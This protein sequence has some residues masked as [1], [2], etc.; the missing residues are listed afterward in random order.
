[1]NRAR[2]TARAPNSNGQVRAPAN[3]GPPTRPPMAQRFINLEQIQRDLPAGTPV[4]LDQE[5]VALDIHWPADSNPADIHAQLFGPLTDAIIAKVHEVMVANMPGLPCSLPKVGRHHQYKH[6]NGNAVQE[7]SILIPK[8][9]RAWLASSPAV[10]RGH[11]RLGQIHLLPNS[12]PIT[13][14]VH[15]KNFHKVQPAIWEISGVPSTLSPLAIPSF[16]AHAYSSERAPRRMTEFQ[17]LKPTRMADTW[18][19]KMAPGS[20]NLPHQSRFSLGRPG[21]SSN[22]GMLVA[23]RL[24]AA[25]EEAPFLMPCKPPPRMELN[26]QR[27]LNRQR[28]PSQQPILPTQPIARLSGPE[29]T[30]SR[31][32]TVP[33]FADVL[34]QHPL[35]PPRQL[36]PSSLAPLPPGAP[37]P[38]APPPRPLPQEIV[39]AAATAAVAREAA[40]KAAEAACKP[41]TPTTSTNVVTGQ[42]GP[43]AEAQP[44]GRSQPR[45]QAPQHPSNSHAPT[46]TQ[47]NKIRKRRL[48]HLSEEERAQRHMAQTERARQARKAKLA[49]RRTQREPTISGGISKETPRP[50]RTSTRHSRQT[51]NPYPPQDMDCD[52]KESS[53]HTRE[54]QAE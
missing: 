21:G 22:Q 26:R 11:L 30:S 41:R 34:R 44:A 31:A 49:L 48:T 52:G 28:L 36:A 20:H 39:D 3:R 1:I 47:Q 27:D 35:S 18:R 45:T 9:G 7:L 32:N 13:V 17:D 24:R 54:P 4:L 5:S 37:Q 25:V 29:P 8:G 51:N 6:P 14:E 38:T 43:P 33:S 46:N 40:A 50:R 2:T 12:P 53:P 19:V 10:T 23:S 15:I 16:L 42:P